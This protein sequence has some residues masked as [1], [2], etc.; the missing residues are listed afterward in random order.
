MGFKSKY[1]INPVGVNSDKHLMELLNEWLSSM[2]PS[3]QTVRL[4]KDNNC[5]I[6]YLAEIHEDGEVICSLV[7]SDYRFQIDCYKILIEGQERICLK[8]SYKSGLVRELAVAARH[9]SKMKQMERA[10]NFSNLAIA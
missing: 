2:M 5:S 6:R 7:L 4:L 1:F 9:Y 3:N 8:V 10:L